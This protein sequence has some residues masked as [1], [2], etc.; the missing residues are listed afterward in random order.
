MKRK[1]CHLKIVDMDK[2]VQWLT[3]YKDGRHYLKKVK[4]K[5]FPFSCKKLESILDEIDNEKLAE[6]IRVL[7]NKIKEGWDLTGIKKKYL[8]DYIGKQKLDPYSAY[9]FILKDLFEGVCKEFPFVNEDMERSLKLLFY[10][11]VMKEVSKSKEF[12]F[13]LKMLLENIYDREIDVRNLLRV[14]LY[15]ISDILEFPK[16][17]ED[18][19]EILRSEI[20][21]IMLK[22]FKPEDIP[23]ELFALGFAQLFV[24]Y[25]YLK[26]KSSKG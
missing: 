24:L 2:L 9:W 26:L 20:K 4:D 14:S 7:A 10:N 25:R 6:A 18:L 5:D 1:Y 22:Y 3:C 19:V 15:I 11:E 17:Q 13:E 16:D 12:I 21:G 23:E 8:R